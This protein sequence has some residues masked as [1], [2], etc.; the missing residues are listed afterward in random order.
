MDKKYAFLMGTAGKLFLDDDCRIPNPNF[1]N[2]REPLVRQLPSTGIYAFDPV[3]PK[4]DDAAGKREMQMHEECV[5][6]AM[7]VRATTDL[8]FGSAAES[9][10]TALEAMQSGK[11]F[12]L[13]VELFAQGQDIPFNLPLTE[14]NR[15]RK[16][17]LNVAR[18]AAR[19][20]PNLP[21]YIVENYG[22]F[23]QTTL[24]VAMSI[25]G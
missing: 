20:H 24:S 14:A 22:D 25:G 12:I 19:K 3:V 11:P 21:L 2:W 10:W 18:K 17:L 13:Y 16:L 9:G 6:Y 1:D 7:A 5:M 8:S 15:P 4:W 23:I